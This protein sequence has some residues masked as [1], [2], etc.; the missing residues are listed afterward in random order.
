VHTD[1]SSS[2]QPDER[3]RPDGPDGGRR[4]DPE[5]DLTG[6]LRS[7]PLEPDRVQVRAFVGLDGRRKLQVRLPLGV[8]QMESEGRPDGLPSA[9]DEARRRRD[10]FVRL[11]GDATGFRLDEELCS[12]LREEARLHQYRCVAHFALG[13]YDRVRGDA[14][15][16]LDILNTCRRFAF[17]PADREALE[18]IRAP[19]LLTRARAEVAAALR[20]GSNRDALD[21]IERGLA[22]LRI[23]FRMVGAEDRFDEANETEALRRMRESLVPKLPASQRIE[24]E[25][26]LRA[27]VASENYELASILR[28]EL[29]QLG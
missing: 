5:A 4:I 11:R 12:A 3:D 21:A 2:S 16:V 28:D 22:A 19:M 18:H 7:W 17:R 14:E 10:E 15:R 6:L 24:L 9:L 27:A 26:R 20:G 23:A 8:L 29:R 1:P 25:E 13:D